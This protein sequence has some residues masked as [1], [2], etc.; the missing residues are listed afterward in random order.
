MKRQHPQSCGLCSFALLWFMSFSLVTL[1]RGDEIILGADPRA[2][3]KVIREFPSESPLPLFIEPQGLDADSTEAVLHA[4]DDRRR[5]GGSTIAICGNTMDGATIIAFSCDAI[6]TLPGASL[7]G[8]GP[9]WC[10]SGSQAEAIA[11]HLAKLGRLDSVFASRLVI[12]VGSL[13]WSQADGFALNGKGT[14]KVGVP[15]RAVSL[16]PV[17]L[18]AS[19]LSVIEAPDAAAAAI[20]IEAGDVSAREAAV[21]IALA[22]PSGPPHMPVSPRA[23]AS[24]FGGPPSRVPR[25]SEADPHSLSTPL[26]VEGNPKLLEFVAKYRKLLGVMQEDLSLFDQYFTGTAG[27]WEDGIYV[28]P[29]RGRCGSPEVPG[30]IVRRKDGIYGVKDAW[31][32]KIRVPDVDTRAQSQDLQREIKS[33]ISALLALAKSITKIADDPTNPDVVW[34]ASH[35]ENLAG[36]H[37]AIQ[38]DKSREYQKFG[39]A[40]RTMK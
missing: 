32:K 21:P 26:E 23:P 11:S 33:S 16:A 10:V 1:A 9:G 15:G 20:A 2:T 31:E 35:T 27:R 8:A 29:V 39:A 34:V 37:T 6:V 18:R 25:P 38:Y 30:S 14:H 36:L 17:F 12:A 5:Q 28:P 13:A 40:V 19:G 4:I 3:A 7:E 22:A 24:P